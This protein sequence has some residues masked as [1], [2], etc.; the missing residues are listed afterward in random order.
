MIL[1]MI[2]EILVHNRYLPMLHIR[3]DFL[4]LEEVFRGIHQRVLEF[5][6]NIENGINKYYQ[7]TLF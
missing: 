1:L 2:V 3:K 5:I 4:I 7:I 6:E